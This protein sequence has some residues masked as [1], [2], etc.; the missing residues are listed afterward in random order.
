MINLAVT[1][2]LG[3]MGQ[4][5]IHL[6]LQDKDFNIDTL[7]EYPG[8]PKAGETVNDISIETSVEELKGSDVII[9]FT[10]PDATMA[11][12]D[13]CVEL[14]VNMVIG[15]TGL[16]AEQIKKIE[17]A[18]KKIGIV[19]SSNMSI[20]VNLV[21]KTLANLSNAVPENYTVKMTEAHHIHKKM[22]LQE[23]PRPLLK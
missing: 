17:E 6:G 21:F 2:C 20:G 1:G 11:N 4:R 7:L 14:G 13:A 5:I 23:Q 18:S 19:F 15:T 8:H 3:R 9:D 22:L 16:N 12:I 10:I